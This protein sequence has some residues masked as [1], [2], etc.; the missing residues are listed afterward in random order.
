[1]ELAPNRLSPGPLFLFLALFLGL[2]V[3]VSYWFGWNDPALFDIRGHQ[4][5][6]VWAEVLTVITTVSLFM[7][8]LGWIYLGRVIDLLALNLGLNGLIIWGYFF[9]NLSAAKIHGAEWAVI[10]A[11]ELSVAINAIG[12]FVLLLVLVCWYAA[13]ALE[14]KELPPMPGSAEA[15][16]R[17]LRGFLYP[18]MVLVAMMIALPMVLTRTVPMLSGDPMLGRMTLEQSDLGRPFYNFASSLLPAVT[19]SCLILASRRKGLSR[20]IL[21]PEAILAGTVIVVQYLTAN[22][23]PLAIMLLI[24]FAL[25]TFERKMPRLMLPLWLVLFFTLYLGLGGFSSILRQNRELLASG[26]IIKASFSE[27]FLGDNLSDLRDGSWVFGEWDFQPLNGKTYLSGLEAVLPSAIFPQK[28]EWYLG[29][30]GIKI[31]H[32]PTREHFGLRLSF[33]AESFLNFGLSGVIGLGVVM[34]AYFG[35]VLRAIHLA[36]RA[37]RPCLTRNL[38]LMLALQ[39]GLTLS[40]SSEGFVFYSI[41]ALLILI[42]LFVDFRL[43]NSSD[44]HRAQRPL[45]GSS[46]TDRDAD[47]RLPS[48]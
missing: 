25:F 34:G 40:N 16:D 26:N 37:A 35:Y 6:A 30:V 8:P 36:A 17:Q 14:R 47:G 45:H 33:F 46:P 31:V 32:W 24:L 20:K 2:Y 48:V 13:L 15:M 9:L 1:M 23:L 11:P 39:L 27:A 7:I 21:N 42:W 5:P 19:A 3:P 44:S 22:R 28:K 29:L 10:R 4:Y 18:V 38:R 43:S 41:L 12:F